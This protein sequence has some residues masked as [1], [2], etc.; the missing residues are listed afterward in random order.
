MSRPRN[1]DRWKR[2]EELAAQ[3]MW[4]SKAAIILGIHHTTAAYIGRRM[5]FD[6][7]TAPPPMPPAP[8]PPGTPR[9]IHEAKPLSHSQYVLDGK[10]NERIMQLMA[11]IAKKAPQSLA[12]REMGSSVSERMF[13]ALLYRAIRELNYIHEV[14]GVPAGVSDLVTTAEGKQV[15]AQGM[16]ALGVDDLSRESLYEPQEAR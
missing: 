8:P 16:R 10:R 12:A 2:A 13:K 7:P 6:W 15:V 9:R 3:G 14:E 11:I 1:H 5:G 4:C